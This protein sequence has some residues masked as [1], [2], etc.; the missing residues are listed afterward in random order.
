LA[1]LFLVGCGRGA[2]RPAGEDG[3]KQAKAARSE[4]E[5]GPVR[6]TVAVDPPQARLSDEPTLTVTL[7][8]EQGVTVRKPVF[9][10]SLGDFVI[11]DFRQ[12][13]P[14]VEGDREILQQIYK[15]EPTRAG[16]IP[17]QPISTTFIDNR[18]GGDG[19]EHSLESEPITVDIASVVDSEVV[20]L[21]QLHPVAGPV[22]LPRGG[23]AAA[24]WLGVPLAMIAAGAIAWWRWRRRR[25]AI[26]AKTLSPQELAYLE[27]DALLAKG[28]AESEVKAFYVELTAIVRR[29]IER[30]TGVR[31]PE[32]TTEEFLRAIGQQATFAADEG[33]RLKS[34]LESA[35]LVK[36][37]A[38]QP[39]KEDI[40]ESFRR[41]KLFVGVGP[42]EVAA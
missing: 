12:P 5:H 22:E 19:K 32:Q 8:Y 11:R 29:Y 40:E 2:A 30:T 10:E 6:M 18:P 20:S 31:A 17:V 16:E 37:A 42:T 28:L 23:G 25:K 39:R 24:W 1:L 33:R 26:E 41:A 3:A 38:H 36:F 7:N 9:G 34:F 4:V 14:K 35:D 21:G 27:L 15:L 13:L